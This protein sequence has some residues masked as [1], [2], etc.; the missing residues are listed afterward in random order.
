MAS[1]VL[2]IGLAGI[3]SVALVGTLFLIA[4][5][6]RGPRPAT[7]GAEP[8]VADD[9]VM[10]RMARSGRARAAGDPIVAALGID[11]VMAARRATR[12]SRRD[13]SAGPPSTARPRQR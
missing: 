2:L 5:R 1:D 4:W 7:M 11:D 10:R 3:A 13:P 8:S 6:R 9:A 12:R